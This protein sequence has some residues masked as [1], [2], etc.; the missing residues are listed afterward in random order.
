MIATASKIES[1]STKIAPTPLGTLGKLPREVRFQIFEM[2]LKFVRKP[3]WYTDECLA[4]ESL[5]GTSQA[6]AVE[7]REALYSSSTVA[8]EFWAYHSPS[9]I[10][11]GSQHNIAI[12]K[13]VIIEVPQYLWERI[14]HDLQSRSVAFRDWLQPFCGTLACKKRCQIHIIVY[15]STQQHF[16]NDAALLSLVGVFAEGL[17]SLS[18]FKELEIHVTL[19]RPLREKNLRSQFL[20]PFS[21]RLGVSIRDS[22]GPILKSDLQSGISWCGRAMYFRPHSHQRLTFEDT[23]TSVGGAGCPS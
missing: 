5:L 17:R 15:W 10:E 22:L 11:A 14:E 16:L 8:G 19:L 1:P 18:I 12:M 9:P 2:V 21:T 13:N 7:A 3:H 4:R 23:K 20:M 6:I